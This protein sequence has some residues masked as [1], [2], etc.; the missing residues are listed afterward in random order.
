MRAVKKRGSGTVRMLARYVSR[1]WGALMTLERVG[2]HSSSYLHEQG[3]EYYRHPT[4]SYARHETPGQL[5]LSAAIERTLA[6]LLNLDA[7][8][9]DQLVERHGMTIHKV[10]GRTTCTLW[11]SGVTLM[12]EYCTPQGSCTAQP[13]SPCMGAT[14]CQP[15]HATSCFPFHTLLVVAG[16]PQQGPQPGLDPLGLLPQPG[17]AVH[18]RPRQAA[19]AHALGAGGTAGPAQGTEPGLLEGHAHAEPGQGGGSA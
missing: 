14:G 8:F 13:V 16:A 5:R 17:Q 15:L 2:L 1:S 18:H 10:C 7:T 11:T 3:V 9:K 4:G 19:G 6:N 12:S